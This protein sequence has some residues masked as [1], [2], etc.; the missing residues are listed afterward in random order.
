VHNFYNSTRWLWKGLTDEEGVTGFI[1]RTFASDP[2]M[3]EPGKR[4]A[5][6][7]LFLSA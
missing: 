3:I 1:S 7:S 5:A 6:K 4:R 2:L